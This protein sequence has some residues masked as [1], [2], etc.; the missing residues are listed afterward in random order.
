M[1]AKNAKRRKKEKKGMEEDSSSPPSPFCVFLRFLRPL[2]G[3]VGQQRRGGGG[4]VSFSG[5][6][7]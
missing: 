5:V 6:V 3:S 4:L 7:R 1:A 2:F